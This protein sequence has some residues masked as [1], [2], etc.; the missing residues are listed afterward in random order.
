MRA[1]SSTESG[2]EATSS[3]RVS[4]ATQPF[5]IARPAN[6]TRSLTSRP[7][8]LSDRTVTQSH[9]HDHVLVGKLLDTHDPG[10][11]P[12]VV[13]RAVDL[14]RDTTALDL[15]VDE[16]SGGRIATLS[17]Q[18]SDETLA[19]VKKEVADAIR[20][21]P[22]RSDPQGIGARH[23]KRSPLEFVKAAV[24]KTIDT[25]RRAVAREPVNSVAKEVKAFSAERL[26]GKSEQ[27]VMRE[28][29]RRSAGSTTPSC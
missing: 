24:T 11:A 19:G 8:S 28:M 12:V 5:R 16:V 9:E 18:V 25:I 23:E 2:R 4:V 10:P 20:G 1:Q 17:K 3:W 29:E 7:N 22:H 15:V 27:Q 13:E 26:K 21:E 14:A 6:M